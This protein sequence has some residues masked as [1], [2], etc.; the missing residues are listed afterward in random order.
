M[1]EK[2]GKPAQATEKIKLSV[3]ITYPSVTV[4]IEVDKEEWGEDEWHRAD[5]RDRIE[6]EAF[7]MFEEKM[8]DG[9]GY[10]HGDGTFLPSIKIFVSKE[11]E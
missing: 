2:E 11:K 8:R 1:S 7:C 4:Q 3:N 10:P 9:Q 6:E 5:V